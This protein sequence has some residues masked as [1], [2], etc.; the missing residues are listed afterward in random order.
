MYSLN[1]EPKL[2][3]IKRILTES[4]IKILTPIG[5]ISVKKKLILP[6]LNHLVL[7]LPNQ[8]KILQKL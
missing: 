4:K 8:A 1:Y 5:K 7:C 3:E 6:K 2:L